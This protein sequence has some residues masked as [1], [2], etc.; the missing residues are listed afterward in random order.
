MK[1]AQG[2]MWSVYD[3]A[4]L[5]LVTTNSVLNRHGALVMG[6]GIARQSR[7]R[8]PGLDTALGKAVM[9]A[10]TRYGLL[11]SPHWPRARLG[12]FQTK[13][14]WHDTSSLELIV[15]STRKLLA[16]CD[17]H[18]TARVHLNMPGVGLGGLTREQVLPAL[19]RLPDAVTVWAYCN[20]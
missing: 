9:L 18:P 13:V 10:G 5:F 15:F 6:A 1:L 2:D 16:W 3:Q 8:F 4:D 19:E 12:A 11:V 17:E 7:E 20:S 14:H